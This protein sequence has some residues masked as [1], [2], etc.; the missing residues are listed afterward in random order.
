[1]R[2]NTPLAPDQVRHRCRNPRCATKLKEPTENP[3]K[4]FCCHGC[5]AAYYRG[6]CI[7]C[8]AKLPPGPSNREI[9]RRTECRAELRKSPQRYRWSRI[10]ERPQRSAHS[11]GLKNGLKPGRPFR[12]V[13][14]P[15]DLHEINLRIPLE[16]EVIARL[17]RA[18]ADYFAARR[19]AKWH[20]ARRALIKRHHPPVNVLGGFKFPGAP[21][22][23]LSPID[24]PAE[25]AIPSRWKPT[26]DGADVPPIPDFLKRTDPAA[27]RPDVKSA[28]TAPLTLELED[29]A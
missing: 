18:H 13:A 20:A 22:I 29:A 25:W 7:V 2:I 12:I 19:K 23:D 16:P 8:E 21:E 17:D 14:G 1:V 9:C 11:T 6:R 15:A 28:V 27:K 10:G 5:H 3:S 4:A 26:G 24:P